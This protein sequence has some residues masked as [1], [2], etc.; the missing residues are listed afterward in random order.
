MR[1]VRAWFSRSARPEGPSASV[2]WYSVDPE[3]EPEGLAVLN[4]REDMFREPIKAHEQGEWQPH[5]DQR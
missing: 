2:P 5:G 1:R 3:D 4:V